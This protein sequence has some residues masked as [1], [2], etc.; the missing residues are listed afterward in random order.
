MPEAFI[1]SAARTP[2]G[3]YLG[4]LS[5]VPA[6][7]LGA[8]AIS[9][10]AW[11]SM[12]SKAQQQKPLDLE[13]YFSSP[14]IADPLHVLD[15]C[16]LSDGAAAFVMTTPE[17]AR[18]LPHAPVSVAACETSFSATSVHSYLS[19]PENP[20]LTQ[21]AFTGPRALSAAGLKV[22]DVDFVNIYDCF[23]ITCLM[24]LEDLGFCEKGG[25]G[26]FF[27]AGHAAPGGSLP[28]N[29]HGGMLSEAYLIG[30]N[31]IIE[32]V[33]Q[34]RG[35]AG[36]RQIEGAEVGVISGYG[37]EQTTLVLTAAP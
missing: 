3:K 33:R 27:E 35:H 23:T 28:V 22:G 11:A 13:A 15:C 19:Q 9:T 7:Q 37:A 2:I 8:V 14:M 30:V 24:Q 20:L 16:L 26:A 17:R 34:I 12:N 5:D 25:A 1:L 6:P 21:A 4:A 29:P 18:D 31:N 10:R 36:V 32:A